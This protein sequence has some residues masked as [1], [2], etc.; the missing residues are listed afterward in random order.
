MAVMRMRKIIHITAYFL[1]YV[2]KNLTGC[3]FFSTLLLALCKDGKF[4]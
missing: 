1:Q 3:F 2:D 4:C